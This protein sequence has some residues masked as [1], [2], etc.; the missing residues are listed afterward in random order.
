MC[1]ERRRLGVFGGT[2]DP[3]HLGH[4][5]SAK[6]IAEAFSLERVL[7]VL[8]ARPPHKPPG[9]AA[10]IADRWR[11]LVL[12]V[13]ESRSAGTMLLDA[14]D[15]EMRRDTPSWTVDTLREIS[16]LHPDCELF[17]IIGADA[18]AEIDTWS[19]PGDL[20]QLA[21]VVVTSRPG[22]NDQN[23]NGPDRGT[24]PE[25]DDDAV[26]A[27][28][29]APLPPVAARGDAR[30]DSSIGGYVHTSGH[31][32]FGHR[33]RGLEVSSSTIRSRVR[34]GLPIEDL[35]GA[36]VS[37]YIHDNR[38]YAAGRTPAPDGGVPRATQGA[39]KD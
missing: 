34:A 23:D 29:S 18:Y 33:I 37:R 19:R 12:A 3:V 8:S 27:R 10:P 6:E 39:G 2:F 20:L 26:H 11:M 9:E 16:A 1:A 14:C 5:A 31:A 21:N 32:I 7:L 4:V 36:A 24:P 28:G 30:Y 25:V 17:F 15:I 35:T 13:E 38:L 22:W